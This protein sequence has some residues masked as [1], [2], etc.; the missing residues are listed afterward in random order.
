MAGADR[1]RLTTSV[2]RILWPRLKALGF[3]QRFPEDGPNWKEGSTIDRTGPNGRDQGLLMGRDKFGHRFGLNA[4]RK[5]SDGSYEWL[6]L[7]S[8]GISYSSLRYTTQEE[9]DAVLQRLANAFESSIVPW[10]DEPPG[11]EARRP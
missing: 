7:E 4:C 8:I 5:R 1:I 9:L 3:R 11:E 6:N 10:L 2:N